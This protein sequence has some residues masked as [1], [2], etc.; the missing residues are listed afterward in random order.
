MITKEMVAKDVD[1][2]VPILNTVLA[3]AAGLVGHPEAGA[4][5][6]AGL[7]GLKALIDAYAEKNSGGTVTAGEIHAKA[8]ALQDQL[9]ADRAAI[10]AELAARFASQR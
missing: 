10:D 6:V 8:L 9:T 3:I 5:A 2:V 4:A 1:T 7:N